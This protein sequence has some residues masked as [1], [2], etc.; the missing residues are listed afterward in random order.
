MSDKQ[1]RCPN[2]STIYKVSVTQLTVA[3]GMVCCPKCSAEFNALLHLFN[4][5]PKV[6]EPLITEAQ[7]STA[8]S[9][10][11]IEPK[12]EQH[13]LDIF[14]RKVANSNITLRTYLNNLNTFNHDPITNYPS[15]NLSSSIH[16]NS[17]S[18][19]R[20]RLYIA[21]WA[22]VNTILALLLVFQFLW[23][24]PNVLQRSPALNQ[25]FISACNLFNCDTL[26]ERYTHI[27]VQDLNIESTSAISTVFSGHLVNEYSKGLKLPLLKISIFQQGKLISSSIKAPNEYLVESLHGIT[28]I[29]QDSP[30]GFK[31][32]INFSQSEF[33]NYKLEVIRP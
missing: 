10:D 1:T 12:Q 32:S 23:F 15:L 13:L 29:P 11:V 30:F 4:P 33:D 3:E 5:Q 28:R 22:I 27:K 9:E 7:D 25:A 21:T 19:P 8:P 14:D 16:A 24:N 20:T 18:K 31:F 6:I 26:D 2:C 17:Q